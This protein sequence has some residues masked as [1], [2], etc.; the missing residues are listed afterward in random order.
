MIQEIS[1]SQVTSRLK[2][3]ED[4]VKAIKALLPPAPLFPHF[5]FVIH[6]DGDEVWC[7]ID[8]PKSYPEMRRKYPKAQLS[9]G[10]R[11]SPVVLV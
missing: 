9:I 4:E 6:A 10:W 5:E 8:L 7:G 1:L 3:L 11:S 2:I